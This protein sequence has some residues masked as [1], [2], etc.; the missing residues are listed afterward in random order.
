MMT[1]VKMVETFVHFVNIYDY[2]ENTNYM[3]LISYLLHNI[4]F[5]S[6]AHIPYLTFI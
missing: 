6:P 5:N 3:E 2:S 1:I 4:N